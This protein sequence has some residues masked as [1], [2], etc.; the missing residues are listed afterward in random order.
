MKGFLRIFLRVVVG[1]LLIV[2]IIALTLNICGAIFYSEFYSTAKTTKPMPG[3]ADGFIPQGVDYVEDG[4]IISGYMNGEGASRLYYMENDT[5]IPTITE[6]KKENGEDF[7]GHCGGVAHFDDYLYIGG[8]GGLYVFSLSN[9]LDGDGEATQIGKFEAGM[10][11]SWVYVYDSYL[12]IGK[13]VDGGQYEAS[14]WQSN[15]TPAGDENPSVMVRFKLDVDYVGEDTFGISPAPECAFSMTHTVQGAAVNEDGIILSTS[16]GI[17]TSHFYFYSFN[18][19]SSYGTLEYGDDD[20]EG[21]KTIPLLYL[22][23]E[24]L[25]Y[26]LKAIPMAEEIEIVDGRVYVA[27]ESASTKYLFG[28]L[29]GGQSFYSFEL[30]DEYFGK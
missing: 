26:D 22:D 7:T 3:L 30:K 10:T 12:Y 24:S 5:T 19:M 27:N 4:F 25:T 29:V 11:A 16:S 2:A 28:W 13:F 17:N 23:S 18:E 21:R 14:D 8:S 15:T 9:V 6:L 20:Y 1:I